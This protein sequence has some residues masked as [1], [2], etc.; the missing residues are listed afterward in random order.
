[1]VDENGIHGG[2]LDMATSILTV[3]ERSKVGKGVSRS[4]RRASQI[5]AVVYGKGMAPCPIAVSPKDLQA[6]IATEA[7]WNTIITLKGAGPFDGKSVILKDLVVDPIRRDM[8]HADFHAIDMTRKVHV[9]VP[10]H[11]VGKSAGEKEGGNLE[12]IRHELEVIC[13]PSAIPQAI[14]VDV[15][16]MEIGDVFHVNDIPAPAGVEIPHD[17]NFTVITVTGHK[18]TEGAAIEGGEAEAQEA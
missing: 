12:I 5:P 1:L 9:M 2:K 6:A 7:G 16:A 8:L 11:P 15:T 18:A 13:L 17:V 4:L 14:E 3:S 10:V